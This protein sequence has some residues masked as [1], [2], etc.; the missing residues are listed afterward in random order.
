MDVSG[1]FSHVLPPLMHDPVVFAVPFFLLLLVIEW[2]AARR[3]AHEEADRAPAGAY[4]RSDAWASIWMGVV[5]IGTSGVLNF[6]ALLA[7]AALFVYVAPW[8]LPADAWY[9]WAIAI[10]GVDLL[11]YVY[12]RMAHRV[13]LIWATHQAHHSSQYFNFATALRQKWNISGDVFLRALLPLFGVPPWIVFASFS[14]NLIYQFWIH[15]ERIDRLWRPIEFVFNTPSHHRVHHGMDQ[16]YLDKNYG[17]IFILWDR[18]FGSFAAET[19]RPHYGLT[20]QVDTYNIWTLQTHEYVAIAR[21]V[22]RARRWRDKLGYLF[23]PP[24]WAPART[25]V[26]AEQQSAPV[27]A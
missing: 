21:D 12:H 9:T 1:V 4:Q 23:G 3:L 25:P 11:Y 14:I 27:G 5:S 24:G 13:R 26:V 2:A 20:K 8:Q 19:A 15:T 17:G 16:Q 10:V 6:I 18:L 22:A 7:Y